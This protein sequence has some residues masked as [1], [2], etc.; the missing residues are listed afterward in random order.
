[1]YNDNL[2]LIATVIVVILSLTFVGCLVI[3]VV[4]CV[5]THGQKKE[6]DLPLLSCTLSGENLMD[7]S[8]IQVFDPAP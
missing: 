5:K 4:N 8:N 2:P 7:S 3:V 6:K 1:M